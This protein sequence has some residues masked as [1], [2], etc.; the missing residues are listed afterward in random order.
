MLKWQL[1]YFNGH[2]S[3]S[4]LLLSF[5]IFLVIFICFFGTKR[6]NMF[7][8][9][10]RVISTYLHQLLLSFTFLL[11]RSWDAILFGA[12]ELSLFGVFKYKDKLVKTKI[13]YLYVYVVC[14]CIQ[15][16]IY[17]PGIDLNFKT[18]DCFSLIEKILA[19][20][21]SIFKFLSF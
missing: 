8:L 6:E 5:S 17:R 13:V 4:I 11:V 15:S 18:V 3:H 14:M 21:I 12:H 20:F 10:S 16:P 7:T 1:L 9:Y 2:L 19:D